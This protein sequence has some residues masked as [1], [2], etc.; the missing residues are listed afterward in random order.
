MR[1]SDAPGS[2]RSPSSATDDADASVDTGIGV[3]PRRHPPRTAATSRTRAQRRKGMPPRI[4]S[5][6]TLVLE[7]ARRSGLPAR[8]A[9]VR[10]IARRRSARWR[11]VRAPCELG[12]RAVEVRLRILEVFVAAAIEVPAAADEPLIRRRRPHERGKIDCVLVG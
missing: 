10:L 12:A 7:A 8:A 11:R 9:E 3:A 6:A 1:R 5:L 4:E 2:S